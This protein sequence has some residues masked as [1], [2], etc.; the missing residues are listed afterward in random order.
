MAERLVVF[1]ADDLGMSAA[2]NAGIQRAA[3]AGLVREASLC[4]TGEA[5]EEGVRTARALAGRL[6][7]GLVAV[8]SC[9]ILAQCSW[10]TPPPAPTLSPSTSATSQVRTISNANVITAADL[11]S[12]IGGGKV[13]EYDRNG[14]TLDQLSICQPQPLGTLGASAIKSR[15]FQAR[16][17]DG[18]RPFPRSSLDKKPDSYALVLQFVD[19]DAVWRAKSI[20]DGWV[21]N[22]LAGRA[23]AKGIKVVRP[24]FEWTPVV[25]EPAIAEVAEVVYRDREIAVVTR[26]G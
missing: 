9:L 5:V 7:V 18:D 8:G 12:P 2:A 3:D 17:P 21:A 20:Y 13:I 16:Y 6:G 25:V 10:F 4:V 22:C 11:P 19:Q 14:R 23:P 26:G 24:G 1:N 15:S